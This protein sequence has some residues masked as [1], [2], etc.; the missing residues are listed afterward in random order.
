[1]RTTTS[2]EKGRA[3][4]TLSEA[5]I[6]VALNIVDVIVAQVALAGA[7]VLPP[8]VFMSFGAD[9]CTQMKRYFYLAV[10]QTCEIRLFWAESHA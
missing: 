4:K 5:R 3:L 9:R 2:S 8:R 6:T 1:M 7:T 10:M